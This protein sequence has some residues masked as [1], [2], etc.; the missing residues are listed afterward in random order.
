MIAT[1]AET[2][3][4]EFFASF[5]VP[6]EARRKLKIHRDLLL[7]WQK[8]VNLVSRETLKDVFRRHFADSLQLI[9]HLSGK[10]ILDVGS[11]GGFPG[12]VL[13]AFGDFSVTC[14][15]SDRKKMLFLEE[16]ARA[17]EIKVTLVTGR[18]EELQTYDFDI[19]CARGFAELSTLLAVVDKFSV[20]KRGVFLKGAKLNA[21]IEKA[22]RFF[23]F[24]YETYPSVTDNRGKIIGVNSV[25]RRAQ[26]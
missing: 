12:L 20:A 3:E 19:V 7:K 22:C 10:K 24:Q 18:I 8:A 16:T 26:P 17:A 5:N 23:D 15:D 21:E 13:A 4:E 11:G 1:K 6:P 14:I 9:P 2:E 25:R